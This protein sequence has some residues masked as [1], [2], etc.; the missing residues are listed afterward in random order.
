MIKCTKHKIILSVVFIGVKISSSS[1]VDKW[2]MRD[3]E[4]YFTEGSN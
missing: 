2:D 1:Q 4:D 3:L